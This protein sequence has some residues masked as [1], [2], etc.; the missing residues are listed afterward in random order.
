[1][2]CY[3]DASGLV[4]ALHDEA[5]RLKITKKTAATRSHSFTEVFSTLTGGRLGIRYAAED[6]AEMI[7]SLSG[8]LDIVELGAAETVD[9]LS[10]AGKLGVRGGRVHDY[11]HAVAAKK[12]GVG[13][14]VTLDEGDFVGLAG[15]EGV[16]ATPTAI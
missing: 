15:P 1:M 10:R 6:A 7:A 9:A 3:W 12:A 4:E 13:K 5:V 11:M 14:L 2:R 16:V 8:D